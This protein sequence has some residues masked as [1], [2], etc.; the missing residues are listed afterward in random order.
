MLYYA[1]FPD[2][3]VITPFLTLVMEYTSLPNVGCC[4][5]YS[6]MHMRY[7][8]KVWC[9]TLLPYARCFQLKEYFLLQE[10]VDTAD[11]RDSRQPD[12]RKQLS[13]IFPLRLKMSWKGYIWFFTHINLFS[14][15]CEF[16]RSSNV[17]Q[18]FNLLGWLITTPD[19]FITYTVRQLYNEADFILT[20][21]DVL[22]MKQCIPS[23]WPTFICNLAT[24][25]RPTLSMTGNTAPC[26][27]GSERTWSQ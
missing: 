13:Y 25:Q 1:Y 7:I 10:F 21:I 16:E 14:Y 17:K 12:T 20:K 23:M 15:D 24:P 4:L 18:N 6:R 2:D 26:C 5:T 3:T 27:A 19:R 8:M 22:S 11:R 9:R